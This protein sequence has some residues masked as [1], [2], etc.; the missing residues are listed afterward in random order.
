MNKMKTS[1]LLLT[2]PL[3]QYSHCSTIRGSSE[4]TSSDE[5]N[6]DLQAASY[7]NVIGQCNYSNVLAGYKNIYG[8]SASSVL[9]TQLGV[10]AG[11][12]ESAVASACAGAAGPSGS[13]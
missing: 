10:A 8:N 7:V 4:I 6:R 9:A 2:P 12:V 13:V 5:V 3:I 11:S 1:L